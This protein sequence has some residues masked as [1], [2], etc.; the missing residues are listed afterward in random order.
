MI[1]ISIDPVILQIG[2]FALRWYGLMMVLGAFAL[3]VITYKEVKRKKQD[4]EFV[5]S[6]ILWVF[7]GAILGARVFHIVDNLNYYL[8][9]P[10]QLITPQLEGL[11]VFGA[12]TGGL[13]AAI[14]YA[15]IK[16]FPTLKLLDAGAV[17]IP[18]AQ[19]IGRVGCLINGDSFGPPTTLPWGLVY[20]HPNAMA[21]LGVATHPTP[22]YEMVWNIMAFT[23]LWKLRT[24][25]RT[26][27]VI[28]FLYLGIYSFGRF[29]ISF[30]RVNNDMLLGLREAQ[31][32]SVIGLAIAIPALIY[33]LK[34]KGAPSYV[35][36]PSAA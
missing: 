13:A 16:K 24:R 23:L 15:R 18:L 3:I 11:A 2:H 8:A 7:I 20:T 14:I 4:G 33:L 36:S 10:S 35:E 22:V 9:H 6:L 34:F 17:G 27:G 32:V 1:T 12:I 29:F 19:V 21:P 31:V 26:D 5:I 30:L 25:V 28:F